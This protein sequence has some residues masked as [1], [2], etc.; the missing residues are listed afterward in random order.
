MKKIAIMGFGTVGG[1]VAEILERN[2]DVIARHAGEKIELSY[3]VDLRDMP[4]SP[5]ANK[6]VK[7]FSYVE[8]DPDTTVVVEA[9]GGCGAALKLVQ[10]AL[11]AGKSVVTSNKQLVAE[12]GLEL[13]ETAEEHHCNFLFEASV[14]GG[15]PLLHPIN[16][17]LGAN[18]ISEITGILNGTTNY[19]LTQM[20]ENGASFDAA[21]QEAQKLGYAEQ[22]PAADVEGIDAGRKICILS[23]LA[24]GK[25]VSPADVEMCGITDI[26][27]EDAAFAEAGG[28]KLK[29][30]GRTVNRDGKLY[31]FVAPHF[32]PADS[33]LAPV[34]DV[35]NAVLVRGSDVGETMF[36]GM[37]AGRYPTASAVLGDVIDIVANPGRKQ[38]VTWAAGAE[39]PLGQEKFEAQYFIRTKEKKSELEKA[40]GHIRWLPDQAGWHGG[41]TSVTTK[42]RIGGA[43][44]QLAACWPVMD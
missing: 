43:G 26:T 23:D 42:Q 21:L 39:K 12:H 17:C 35:Y 28:M 19:I 4:D 5:F 14:G 37:G 34:S 27:A 24:F 10:R 38:P 36:Y 15:I 13:I 8:N 9:I 7:D 25:N 40:L 22:N 31:V 1:G 30:L 20:L 18:E 32:V 44:L 6:M 16:R 29:L 3:I 2:A 41:L 33:P 11:A